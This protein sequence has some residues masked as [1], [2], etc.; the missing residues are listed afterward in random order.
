MFAGQ[1]EILTREVATAGVST[2][3]EALEDLG[4]NVD[5]YIFNQDGTQD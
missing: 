1:S 5:L 4:R 2:D 3:E